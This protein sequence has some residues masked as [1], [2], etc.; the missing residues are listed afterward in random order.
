M[1]EVRQFLGSSSFY[2]K[3]VPS[4][5]KLARSL[6]SLTKKNA[7]FK[8]TE[9]CQQAFELLKRKLTEAPVLAYP[10]FSTGFTIETDASY[11]GLGAILSQEQEDGCLYPVSYASR[12]LSPAEQNYGITD[13]ET[14]AVVWAVTH[15]RHYL[16]NQ[17]VRILLIM[18]LLS[19]FYRIPTYLENM[20]DGGRRYTG[21]D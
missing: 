15:F 21:V 2:H 17:H 5:A 11:S 16:Y 9:E 7:R 8:W 4:F 6:H 14:L 18:Q 10:N 3:F 13:L 20:P 12:A 19:L 1:K